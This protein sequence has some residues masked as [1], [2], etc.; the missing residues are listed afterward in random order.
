[1]ATFRFRAQ[2]ALVARQREYDDRRRDL[3]RLQG[4]RELARGRLRAAEGACAEARRV[5]D[6][7]TAGGL[8]GRDLEWYR[9][10]SLRLHTE[11]DAHRA[12]VRALDMA[13]ARAAAA[14]MDAHRRRESLERFRQ[15][16]RAAFDA[17]E[18]AQERRVIDEL[19][20]RRFTRRN[21]IG[22][23]HQLDE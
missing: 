6:E 21:D 16:A 12:Q 1:M 22:D 11:C 4:E 5:I 3:A 23:E 2:A 17:A 7:V 15:R 19:A 10:W 8:D 18:A 14:C 9:L 13:V 20:A